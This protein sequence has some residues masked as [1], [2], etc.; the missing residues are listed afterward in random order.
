MSI[1]L[2]GSHIILLNE[3][4]S[5]NRFAADLLKEVRPDEGTIIVASNQT[6]GRGMEMNTWE[7][8]P[9]KNLTFTAILYPAFLHIDRQ[10]DLN[11]AISLGVC[12][13]IRQK[14]PDRKICIKWPNDIY[15]GDRKAAGIL[16]RNSIFGNRF[17]SVIAGIGV[18]M[19][20]ES[21]PASLPNPVSVRN[22]TGR[23]YDLEAELNALASTLDFR[24]NQ[25]SKGETDAI[26]RDYLEALYRYKEWHNF[27]LRGRIR[28]ARITGISSNGR[29]ILD[30]RDEP[31]AEFDIKEVRFI[32]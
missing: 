19:N 9:F 31:I 26:D 16:I 2:I 27:E 22:S 10:F 21:F 29:L 28:E 14:V 7:S 23:E 12:D 1:K 15:I 20:Q 4:D 11:K 24:Y 3:V 18:N 17:D 6:Q 32:P 30:A 8:E 5:T 25:L 13:F